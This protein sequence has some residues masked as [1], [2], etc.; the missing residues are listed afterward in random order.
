MSKAPLEHPEALL[1]AYGMQ[2][3]E[4]ADRHLR[5]ARTKVFSWQTQKRRSPLLLISLDVKLDMHVVSNDASS[6]NHFVPC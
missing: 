6:L 3:R 5:R 2:R 1:A 4:K